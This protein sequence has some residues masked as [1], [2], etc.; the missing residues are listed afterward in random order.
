AL[1]IPAS[2]IRLLINSLGCGEC[3]PAYRE[4]VSRYLK[5]HASELCD[6][7]LRRAATN[8]LRAFD[9]KNPQCQ[10]TME[11]APVAA[12]HLCDACKDHHDQVKG[13]LSAAGV[14]FVEDPQLV[15][16]L[17]YYTRTVFEVQV[18]EG[19]GSQNA[20]GGGGRYDKLME[21]IGGRPTPGFGFALGFERIVLALQAAGFAFPA[22]EPYDA[23]VACVDGSVRDTAFKVLQALRDVG[24]TCDMDHQGRSL[25]SQFKAADKFAA[26]LVF[27][28]GPDELASASIKVRDMAS[29]EEATI[30]LEGLFAFC[31]GQ[32][33]AGKSQAAARLTEKIFNPGNVEGAL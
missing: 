31:A 16:G 22:A 6:D 2:T 15:R 19:L 12:E 25:K 9:C 3:R 27:I 13:Y 33:Q 26:R 29:H 30:S 23:F 7:C 17:D 4:M 10:A 32:P 18:T 14:A 21:E 20:I 28:L 1:G 8:P 24:L 11:G 5:D